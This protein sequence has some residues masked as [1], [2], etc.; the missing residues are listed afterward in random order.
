MRIAK[1][2]LPLAA[3]CVLPALACKKGAEERASGKPLEPPLPIPAEQIDRVRQDVIAWVKADGFTKAERNAFDEFCVFLA[4][5]RYC[6]QEIEGKRM[7]EDEATSATQ[8]LVDHV[9]ARGEPAETVLLQLLEARQNLD[10]QERAATLCREDPEIFAAVVLWKI[11]STKAVAIFQK[12]ARDRRFGARAVF[13]RGLARIGDA[14]ALPFLQEL[15]QSD[16]SR[17]VKR[18]ALMGLAANPKVEKRG[19]YVAALMRLADGEVLRFLNTLAREDSDPEIRKMAGAAVQAITAQA[20]MPPALSP[21][22]PPAPPGGPTDATTGTAP[23]AP[24]PTLPVPPP[25]P[26]VSPAATAPTTQPAAR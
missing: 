5:R 2:V 7:R 9:A 24:L 26:I 19:V 20:E 14:S 13:V 12:M 22:Q 18:E 23:A 8:P 1:T 10:D 3:L 4:A 21:G 25:P 6:D 17:E 15:V 16:D 11:K